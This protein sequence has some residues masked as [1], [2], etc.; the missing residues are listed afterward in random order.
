MYLFD[1]TKTDCS[2]YLIVKSLY[3]IIYIIKFNFYKIK[4][5][6]EETFSI[7]GKFFSSNS[8]KNNI[9]FS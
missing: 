4:K 8:T 6:L 5:K 7:L 1:L 2:I 3:K 9:L